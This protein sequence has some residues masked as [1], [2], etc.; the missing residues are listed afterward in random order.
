MSHEGIKAM[1]A[2]AA[3]VAV[4]VIP[5]MGITGEDAE[6][7]DIPIPGVTLTV[8]DFVTIDVPGPTVRIPGPTVRV[9]GPTETVRVPL[10]GETVTVRPPRATETV[11]IPG[12]TE[13]VTVRPDN[14]Q[15]SAQPSDAPTATVTVSP[16]AGQTTAGSGTVDP[17]PSDQTPSDDAQT[18]ETIVKKVAIGLLA[19][20]V[21]AGLG[22]LAMFFGYIL[23]RGDERRQTQ[24]FYRSLLRVARGERPKE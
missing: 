21:I 22:I 13:T 18:I 15:P 17:K 10:P 12:P 5:F 3:A 6:A 2:T 9:P 23:G 20:L 8:T 24:G 1:T 11:R 4:V 19:T 16:E 7:S 14:P